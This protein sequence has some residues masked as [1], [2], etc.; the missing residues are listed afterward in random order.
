MS[1]EATIPTLGAQR[2]RFGFLNWG[3]H[4]A[5]KMVDVFRIFLNMMITKKITS[6][7]SGSLGLSNSEHQKYP[8]MMIFHHSISMYP[9]FLTTQKCKIDQ[10]G[11][12]LN[13]VC[14][15]IPNLSGS[16]LLFFPENRSHFC[17]NLKSHKKKSS[18][19][20]ECRNEV[21]FSINALA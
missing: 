2:A 17:R 6:T 21:I 15:D 3:H 7:A 18:E 10:H 9:R 14:R 8:K 1:A 4:G 16:I 13:L 5:I 19:S 11:N 20:A 12:R